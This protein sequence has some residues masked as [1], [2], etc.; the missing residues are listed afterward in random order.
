MQLLLGS[1]APCFFVSDFGVAAWCVPPGRRH[2]RCTLRWAPLAA[3]AVRPTVRS[4]CPYG[5]ALPVDVPFSL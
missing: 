2:A 4:R 3:D 1:E 5:V